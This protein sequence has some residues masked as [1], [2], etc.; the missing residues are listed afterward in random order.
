MNRPWTSPGIGRIFAVLVLIL[1]ALILLHV[2]GA[3]TFLIVVM[4]ALLA[5][6][7]LL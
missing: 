5:L 2:I 3:S 4:I 1:D 7:L 6:A